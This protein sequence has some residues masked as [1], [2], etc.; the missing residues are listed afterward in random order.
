MEH[1][2]GSL[3]LLYA[4]PIGFIVYYTYN[5]ILVIDHASYIFISLFINKLASYVDNSI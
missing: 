3:P 1:A 2:I 4:I 5:F